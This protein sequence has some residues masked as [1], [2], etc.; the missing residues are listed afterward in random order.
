EQLCVRPNES[1]SHYRHKYLHGQRS[2]I[3]EP[4]WHRVPM[5]IQSELEKTCPWFY[6]D[7]YPGG[8][9]KVK[10]CEGAATETC[11]LACGLS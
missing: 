10:Q 7:F 4:A 1:D 6:E 8:E 5:R 2:S 11:Y 3:V 9:L